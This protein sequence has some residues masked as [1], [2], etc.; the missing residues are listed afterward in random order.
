MTQPDELARLRALV[1]EYVER[2]AIYTS[3][4]EGDEGWVY[5]MSPV[6]EKLK[7]AGNAVINCDLKKG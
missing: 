4:T 3:T 2:D 1:R 7:D 6:L 5:H